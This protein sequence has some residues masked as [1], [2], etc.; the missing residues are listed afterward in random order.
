MLEVLAGKNRIDF[1]DHDDAGEQIRHEVKTRE[2]MSFRA[3]RTHVNKLFTSIVKDRAGR[4]IWWL[5]FL[6]ECKNIK[7]RGCFR[8]LGLLRAEARVVKDAVARGRKADLVQEAM[9]MVQDAEQEVIDEEDMD[10]DELEEGFLYG[11]ENQIVKRLRADV[12]EKD[13]IIEERNELLEKKDEIIEERNELLE[14]NEALLVEKNT[15]IE[16]LK[17]ELKENQRTRKKR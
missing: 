16:R 7:G 12:I 15:E 14:K 13:E 1:V 9:T 3:L 5:V 10:E 8:F 11:V 2:V 17:E 4:A 6:R